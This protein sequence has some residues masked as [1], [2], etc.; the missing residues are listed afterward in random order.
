LVF[1]EGKI[2]KRLKLFCSWDWARE[3]C[4]GT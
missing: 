3:R 4:A 1:A 2:Y